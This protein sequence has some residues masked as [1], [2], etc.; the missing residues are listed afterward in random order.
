MIVDKI[1]ENWQAFQKSRY[2]TSL[3]SAQTKFR[4]LTLENTRLQSQ[5]LTTQAQNLQKIQDLEAQLQ[6]VSKNSDQC[7]QKIEIEQLSHE[8]GELH[9]QKDALNGTMLPLNDSLL[10]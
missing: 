6:S 9:S 5:L 7:G 4:L 1:A 2:Q 8:I 10:F 3:K